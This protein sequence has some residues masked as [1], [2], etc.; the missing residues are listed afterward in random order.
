MRRLRAYHESQA[1]NRRARRGITLAD[2]AGKDVM[3][4]AAE[5]TTPEHQAALE[6]QWLKVCG[7][8]GADAD[9][10]VITSASVIEYAAARRTAGA[11]GQTIVREI[12]AI[13]RGCKIAHDGGWLATVP[14]SWPRM[15]R[16]NKSTKRK[17]RLHPP[18]VLA[19][20][21]AELPKDARDE[22][23]LA[24]LTGLRARELKRM[25]A[26]WVE[27]APPELQAIGI[28][29]VLR[30]PAGA[31]KDRDE[32][33]L[34]MVPRALEIIRRRAREADLSAPLLHQGSHKTA[35]RLARKRIGYR[36]P[37]SLRD[38][39]HTWGTLANRAVGIDAARDGLGHAN[40]A[41]TNR[42]V[43]SDMGRLASATLA[44][45]EL[46]GREK[47]AE[48][49]RRALTERATR[50]ELATLSFAAT[51]VA[52]NAEMLRATDKSRRSPSSS[53]AE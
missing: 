22:A 40:L 36:T 49:P 33:V 31:A 29:V 30:V 43:S 46:V 51:V 3:R 8:F 17:G 4:A 5:G 53:R 45:A 11:L 1:P 52:L 9:P 10:R 28:P 34:P 26:R 16:D 48:A 25:V 6:A 32:R 44:V 35:Y 23:E 47:P 2:L 13:R 42:Y 27:P 38:L 37:I 39:R 41:T 14:Q 12:Q 24:I 18:A 50:F 20:W 7:H 21:L 19:A 15:R